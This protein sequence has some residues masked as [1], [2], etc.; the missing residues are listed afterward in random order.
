MSACLI[1]VPVNICSA[2]T[3]GLMQKQLAVKTSLSCKVWHSLKKQKQKQ[4]QKIHM[5]N[6][7]AKSAGRK[8]SLRFS[9]NHSTPYLIHLKHIQL[10]DSYTCSQETSLR[11][12]R[13][14][15]PK[16]SFPAWLT[17]PTLIY[18]PL[19]QSSFHAILLSKHPSSIRLH[20]LIIRR[21]LAQKSTRRR[22]VSQRQ[23]AQCPEDPESLTLSLAFLPKPQEVVRSLKMQRTPVAACGFKVF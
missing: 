16:F 8:K 5:P 20:S 3:W 10:V 18:C 23:S 1:S 15:R 2:I 14:H 6:H 12:Q 21:T 9:P 7:Y 13:S 4:N 17:S 11:A 22:Q 19:F